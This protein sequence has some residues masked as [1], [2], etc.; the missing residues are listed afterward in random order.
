MKSIWP[1]NKDF[2]FTIIDDTDN[3][4]VRNTEPVYR[5]LE[6]KGL[7]TTKTAWAFPPRDQY[8][9]SSLKDPQYLSFLLDLK[10][11]GFEIAFHNAGSGSFNRQEILAGLEHFQKDIGHY[12]RLHINHADNPDN[13]YWGHKRFV[14]PLSWLFRF[15][16]HKGFSGEDPSSEHFWGDK[17][18]A[19]ITYTRNHVF[20][21]INTL[22]CD[23]C[24]PYRAGRKNQYSNFWFS[25]S[26]GHTVEEFNALLTPT[27]L[28]TLVQK[29]GAC[30][31][32][33]HLASGFLKENGE[34]DPVFR[35][36]VSDLAGRNGWF[37]P[38]SEILDHLREKGNGRKASYKYLLN[39]DL[40]WLWQ[41]VLK[42]IRTG[43]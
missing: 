14:P 26:D 29:K 3:G 33:T 37:A 18:K 34:L 19:W 31:V 36:R 38:A 17:H 4:T 24:M 28:D 2:A 1:E 12:P 22:S 10:K 21:T 13:I 5:F 20:N 25:S 32:Y 8:T 11:K 43:R 9:G 39:L 6:E 35:E 15:I 7:R 40:K 30:I 27:A 41:R 16:G 23:P 42:R